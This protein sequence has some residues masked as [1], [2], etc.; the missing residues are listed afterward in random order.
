MTWLYIYGALTVGFVLGALV[1]ALLKVGA[2]D[3]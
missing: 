1:I 2:D 3:E